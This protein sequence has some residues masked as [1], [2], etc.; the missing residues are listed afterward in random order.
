[1]IIVKTERRKLM[2]GVLETEEIKN[3]RHKIKDVPIWEKRLLTIEEAALLF[4]IGQKKL[5]RIVEDNVGTENEFSLLNGR[6]CLINRKKF[7]V[8]LDGATVI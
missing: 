4:N 6:K 2:N 5:R 1:M 7:E 8:F 3:N